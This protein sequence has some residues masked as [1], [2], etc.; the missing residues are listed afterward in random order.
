MS[1]LGRRIKS[2]VH[3]LSRA[4]ELVLLEVV[5]NRTVSLSLVSHCVR[6]AGNNVSGVHH[7]KWVLLKLIQIVIVSGEGFHTLKGVA[8]RWHQ[9]VLLGMP[10]GQR[11]L[12]R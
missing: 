3:R 12:P 11:F 2:L 1:A 7:V 9:V 10:S 8:L 5:L 6:V 4:L